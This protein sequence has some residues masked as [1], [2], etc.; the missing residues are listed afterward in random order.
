VRNADV[1]PGYCYLRGHPLRLP[2]NSRF[3]QNF[4]RMDSSNRILR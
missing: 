4:Q 1:C 3:S 2:G